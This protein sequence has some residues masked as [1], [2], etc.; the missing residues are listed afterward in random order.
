MA[1]FSGDIPPHFP[2]ELSTL[3]HPPGLVDLH[4]SPTALPWGSSYFHPED[5]PGAF[6]GVGYQRR[7]S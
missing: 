5:S 3:L 4:A 2:G 7:L 6:P 1:A